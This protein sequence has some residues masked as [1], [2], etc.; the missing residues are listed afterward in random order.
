M[1]GRGAV[2]SR[3]NSPRLHR[4]SPVSFKSRG[5]RRRFCKSAGVGSHRSSPGKVFRVKVIEA[6]AFCKGN[7]VVGLL[8]F[9]RPESTRKKIAYCIHTPRFATSK[10]IM[11]VGRKSADRGTCAVGSI[12]EARTLGRDAETQTHRPGAAARA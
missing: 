11:N 8:K 4:Q 12:E 3:R 5:H 9:H 1:S 2:A 6:S 10:H 7:R